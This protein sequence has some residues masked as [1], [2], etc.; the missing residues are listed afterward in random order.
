[1]A[2]HL[3]VALAAMLHDIGKFS[4]RA[5]G[6]GKGIGPEAEGLRGQICPSGTGGY[7]THLHS[8]Y[9]AQ[10]A[11]EYLQH[12][13]SELDRER[14]LRLAAYHH[15]PTDD[16]DERLV[17][18]ADRLSSGMEREDL[19]EGEGQSFRRVPLRA[20]TNEV[21]LEDKPRAAG[22]WFIPLQALTPGGLSPKQA[23][24][25][26]PDLTQEYASLWGHFTEAWSRNRVAEPLGFLNRAL[27]VLEHYTWCIPAATNTYPDISLFDHLK[28]TA[29]IA[30]ALYL[31]RRD[32]KEHLL[33]VT[34]DCG[35]IQEYLYSVKHG[36]GG[37][38]RQLRARSLFVSLLVQNVA[39]DI[40]RRL[41]LPLCNCLLAAGGRFTLLLPATDQAHQT[42][43][44]VGTE[45]DDWVKTHLGC[46]LHP[47]LAYLPLL[48]EE[49]ND[50]GDLLERLAVRLEAS[51]ARPLSTALQE[52]CQWRT[53]NFAMP[54]LT[55]GDASDLCDACG[56]Y[57]GEPTSVR[58]RMV[59]ICAKCS[60]QREL[61]R[62][63]V[64]S[65]YA[66]FLPEPGNLP[67]GTLKLVESEAAIPRNAYL[68]LDL[69]GGCGEQPDKPIVSGLTARHVPRDGDGSVMEFGDLAQQST[70]RPALAYL[71][72]DVDNLGLMFSQG[73]QVGEQ[74]DRRSVSR[75]TT[76]SRSLEALFAGHVQKLAEDIG[77]IYT[78][79]S[80]GDDLLVIGP[81]NQV[82]RFAV[83]LREDFRRF[84][85]GNA[86][87][88]LTAG[89]ALVGNKTPVLLATEA[90][91]ERLEQG[92]DECGK[93]RFVAFGSSLSWELVPT[94][95]ARA[96]QVLSWLRNDDL[97]RAQVRRLLGYARLYQ[98]YQ[99]TCDAQYL[100]YAPLLVYD[101]RR[102]WDK[103]PPEAL[104]WA[105]E[106]S[107]P[108][109][110]EM[111]YLRFV[112]EYALN[113]I[114]GD[115]EGRDHS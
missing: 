58:D 64:G 105:R 63:L 24:S 80:G 112:C 6:P 28:A 7:A 110:Q 69:E 74:K 31:A 15:R 92:K 3:E 35:G 109:S 12:L 39:H 20:I 81:W 78:V 42:I 91:A 96:E 46:Q 104:E 88:S 21:Q 38:A 94:A 107:V 37:L 2:R 100:R 114:R 19:E 57:P 95:L 97:R 32:R 22:Q 49:L 73:L 41:Q 66:A 82:V 13:P 33:L 99:A 17:T 108:D 48:P 113:G 93:D 29:A 106:L 47:H 83:R 4:Q 75:L 45:L 54:P 84:T 59:A 103:A 67:F 101:I 14:V 71:K 27:S 77:D 65:R 18:E 23:G 30:T 87:W 85:C 111:P 26:A 115:N 55:T 72:A 9:T 53:D 44:D 62:Q 102:N 25:D 52:D 34:G 68:A 11:L 61:G 5:Y 56:L 70:G 8:L 1:M 50:F 98:Q 16:P 40:L 90:A 43:R 36:A 60:A 86:S 51:K 76:L 79:Y 10:F 89:L